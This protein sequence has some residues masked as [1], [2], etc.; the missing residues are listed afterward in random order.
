MLENY[1]PNSRM[2]PILQRQLGGIWGAGDITG[3]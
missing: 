3:V 2:A 1:A